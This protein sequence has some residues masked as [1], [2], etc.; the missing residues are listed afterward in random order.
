MNEWQI[1]LSGPGKILLKIVSKGR[2]YEHEMSISCAR[3]IGQTLVQSSKISG[4]NLAMERGEH[5]SKN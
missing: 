3:D 4:T 1:F 5:V 2:T